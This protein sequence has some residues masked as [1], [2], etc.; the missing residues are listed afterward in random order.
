MEGLENKENLKF[1]VY[2]NRRPPGQIKWAK[3]DKNYQ[4][5]V[6]QRVRRPPLLGGP[7]SGRPPESSAPLD[8]IRGAAPDTDKIL[9]DR[10]P[11]LL[12]FVYRKCEKNSDIVKELRYSDETN[13]H[14]DDKINSKK[15]GYWLHGT[16]DVV[17]EAPLYSVK[18]TRVMITVQQGRHWALLNRRRQRR[19]ADRQR[20]AVPGG[21]GEISEGP[22]DKA[23]ERYGSPPV[24]LVP[25][26]R[27][28]STPP[29]KPRIGYRSASG[30]A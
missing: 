22:Q 8:K 14:V 7:L 26:G 29:K 23:E 19:H 5:I 25:T 6:F 4:F 30:S 11:T 13:F 1:C 24:L 9:Q 28:P 16:P 20:S 15:F 18:I 27:C 10:S 17:A 3:S 21:A 2:V 12:Y